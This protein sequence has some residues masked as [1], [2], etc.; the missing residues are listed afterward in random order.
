MLVFLLQKSPLRRK[1]GTVVPF[2][3]LCGVDLTLVLL[4]LRNPLQQT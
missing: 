4:V 2:D 3:N 1:G